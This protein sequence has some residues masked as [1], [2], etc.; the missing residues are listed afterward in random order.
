MKIFAGDHSE[1][2]GLVKKVL[3][4]RD[5]RKWDA[6]FTLLVVFAVLLASILF[7]ILNTAQTLVAGY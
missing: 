2:G 3:S 5:K 6:L 7:N 4:A 1:S